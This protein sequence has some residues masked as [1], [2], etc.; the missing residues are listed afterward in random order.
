MPIDF[1]L[2]GVRSGKSA[3]AEKLSLSY[4]EE[5][6]HYIA[7]AEI[8]DEA[9][10]QRIALH[11]KRRENHGWQLHEE[12]VKIT[13]VINSLSD[14]KNIILL[15][16]MDMW[17]NNLL[18]HNADIA[19]VREDFLAALQSFKGRLVIVSA[20]VGLS[21]LPVDS[22][23]RLYC[24]IVGEWNQAVAAVSDACVFVV[25]GLPLVLKG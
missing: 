12:A 19:C 18:Y 1:I 2:G 8:V 15:D 21:L 20:E 10:Q 13:E 24:D 9:L 11:K 25:A 3:Y 5:N 22:Q 14:S 7:S 4:G 16:S 23:S 17:I 6:L